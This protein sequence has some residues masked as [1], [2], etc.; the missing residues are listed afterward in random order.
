MKANSFYPDI[1]ETDWT[2]VCAAT[3][4]NED[5]SI[6]NLIFLSIINRHLPFKRITVLGNSASRITN[7]F[8]SL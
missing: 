6:F 1:L 3:D 8:L 2:E 7:K 4:V 5:V